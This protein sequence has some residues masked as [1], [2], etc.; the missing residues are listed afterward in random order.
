[1]SK[2]IPVGSDGGLPRWS[3]GAQKSHAHE[4]VRGFVWAAQLGGHGGHGVTFRPDCKEDKGVG[5]GQQYCLDRGSRTHEIFVLLI[6]STSARMIGGFTLVWSY[7]CMAESSKLFPVFLHNTE[8]SSHFCQ[9][10]GT[11]RD[12]EGLIHTLLK[13]VM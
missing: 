7:I 3:Q 6:L 1:M 8:T 10:S 4:Y 12:M 13:E 9:I 11:S 2:K 5:H